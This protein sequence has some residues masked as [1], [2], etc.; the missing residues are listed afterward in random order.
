[1]FL[2]QAEL[3]RVHRASVGNRRALESVK[4]CG[5]FYCLEMFA[6]SEIA[7]WATDK[8]GDTALCPHCGV[9][10]IVPSDVSAF[11]DIGLL[12]EMKLHWFRAREI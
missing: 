7:E 12:Q 4:A 11:F 10:A 3:D 9:D 2:E 5:C 6:P 8:E 1:M